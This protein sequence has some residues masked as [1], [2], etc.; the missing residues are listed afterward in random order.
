MKKRKGKL[1]KTEREL[2]KGRRAKRRAERKMRERVEGKETKERMGK[3]EDEQK[4]RE[5]KIKEKWR[6]NG[7]KKIGIRERKN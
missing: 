4:C 3:M 2:K 6:G 1:V 5:E 7:E